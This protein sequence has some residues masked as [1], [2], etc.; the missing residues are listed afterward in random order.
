MNLSPTVLRTLMTTLSPPSRHGSGSAAP[1][2]QRVVLLSGTVLTLLGAG[3][4][5]WLVAEDPTG[6]RRFAV[7]AGALAIA[8]VTLISAALSAR[9]AQRA[10]TRSTAALRA[11]LERATTGMAATLSF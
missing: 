8:L 2:L 11:D 10:A 7:L 9:S 3:S 6:T 1:N 4:V 5:A